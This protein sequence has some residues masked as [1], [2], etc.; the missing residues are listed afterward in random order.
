MSN[1]TPELKHIKKYQFKP[2]GKETLSRQ[3][4][5][6]V[7]PSLE[8]KLKAKKNWNQF[9]REILEKALETDGKC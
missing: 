1:P 8:A 5:I 2:K 3:L 6:K 4:N 9:A 7:T